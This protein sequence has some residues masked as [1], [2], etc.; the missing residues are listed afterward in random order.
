LRVRRCRSTSGSLEVAG[1]AEQLPAVAPQVTAVLPR[2]SAILPLVAARLLVPVASAAGSA[3][4]TVPPDASCTRKY[5]PG[6]IVPD[7]GVGCH[8]VPAEVAYWTLQPETSTVVVPPLKSS[9]KS[10]R[11]VAPLFP[12]PP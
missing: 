5:R 11:N 10:F 3:A 8:D 7:S 6:A 4:P 12:P 9:T 1:V 2:T